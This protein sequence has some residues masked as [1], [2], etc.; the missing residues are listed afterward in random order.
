MKKNTEIHFIG[1]LAIQK[2]KCEHKHRLYEVY[3]L[4]T[5]KISVR[6]LNAAS[7]E[8]RMAFLEKYIIICSD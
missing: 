5:I 8:C 3:R 7:F 6:Y 2:K 4:K 1:V